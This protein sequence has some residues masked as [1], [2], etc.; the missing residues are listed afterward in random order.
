MRN[1]APCLRKNE[2]LDG[3]AIGALQRAIA[4]AKQRWLVIGWVTKKLFINMFVLGLGVFMY[5]T[6]LQ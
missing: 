4:T 1:T 5:E 6:Y 2:E 3:P